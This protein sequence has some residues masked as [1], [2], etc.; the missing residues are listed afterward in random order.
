MAQPAIRAGE[1]RHRLEI[2]QKPST[3]TREPGGGYSHAFVTVDTVSAEIKQLSGRELETAKTM[4]NRT[5]HQVKLRFYEGLD[6]KMRFKFGTKFYNIAD[7]E[8]VDERE[9]WQRVLVFENKK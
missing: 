6:S 2:Q 7:V 4:D 1:L 3:P 8:D 9:V 5:T